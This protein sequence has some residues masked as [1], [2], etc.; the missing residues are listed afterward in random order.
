M[1]EVVD[2]AL[3]LGDLALELGLLALKLGD[4]FLLLD[5][6]HLVLTGFGLKLVELV[7]DALELAAELGKGRARRIEAGLLGLAG[8]EEL[9]EQ[10]LL[11]RAVLHGLAHVKHGLAFGI[12]HVDR[13]EL[14]ADVER[15]PVVRFEVGLLERRRVVVEEVGHVGNVNQLRLDG[16]RVFLNLERRG[17]VGFGLFDRLRDLH[18]V[19]FLH[20]VAVTQL[21]ALGV[22]LD[23]KKKCG[24]CKHQEHVNE[25]VQSFI[26]VEFTLLRQLR[27]MIH[28][29]SEIG[30]GILVQYAPD[31]F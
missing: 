28:N 7:H 5:D 15:V 4:L 19:V 12:E 13:A 30:K 25:N 2:L 31:G 10:L 24:A 21:G 8:R 26:H 6:G 17:L 29:F 18:Q 22:E 11:R 9:L 20:A 16:G 23:F 27:E 3:E 14:L 1:S